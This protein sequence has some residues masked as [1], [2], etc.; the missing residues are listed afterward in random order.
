MFD[1]DDCTTAVAHANAPVRNAAMDLLT[2][3]HF[4][5]RLLG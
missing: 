3:G 4:M 2:D 5:E 1:G